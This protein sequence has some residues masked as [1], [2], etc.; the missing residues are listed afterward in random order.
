MTEIKGKSILVRVSEGSS[1]RD[2]TVFHILLHARFQTKVPKLEKVTLNNHPERDHG[3]AKQV[4]FFI[5]HYL[6]VLT[7][8]HLGMLK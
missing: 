7:V 4:S 6:T 3:F 1:Y 5:A 2:S 8:L